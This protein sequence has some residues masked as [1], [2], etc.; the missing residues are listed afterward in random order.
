[1]RIIESIGARIINLY[2]SSAEKNLVK[3]LASGVKGG[4]ITYPCTIYHPELISLGQGTV[5]LGDSRL[6]VFPEATGIEAKIQIGE[7]CLIGYRFCIL[8][9]AD[10][11]IGNNCSIASNVC[12]VSE[13]HGF[14]PLSSV[15]YG[16]Q[17]LIVAPVWIGDGCWI[18]EKV[19]IL[20][21]VTIGERSVV[22]AGAVVTKDVPAYS[23]VAGNP[24]RIIKK[25]DFERK[26]WIRN[27]ED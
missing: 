11:F 19:T 15:P 25:F 20:P 22:G 12:I 1:M 5:I 21:G 17:D 23:V 13:N 3:S 10:I 14:N 8:A 7:K 2:T 26:E 9:G 6:Q 27:G 24:A 4:K 16:D 18:G